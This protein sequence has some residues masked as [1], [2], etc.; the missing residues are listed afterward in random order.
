MSNIS[1]RV[2][3]SG[4]ILIPVAVCRKLGLK[5]GKS[6]LLLDVDETP[7]G[8]MTRAQA[9]ARVQEWAA[10]YAKPGRVVSEELI[11]ERRREAARESGK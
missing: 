5:E 8:V 6:D 1:V 7:V 2:E 3:K 4:R 10:R 11:A 9:L